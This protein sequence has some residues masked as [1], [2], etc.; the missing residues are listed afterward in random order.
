MNESSRGPEG[1]PSDRR[2]SDPRT[3]VTPDAFEISGDLLGLPLAGPWSRLW[4]L[5][6]DGILI[7]LLS[8]AGPLLLGVAAAV[9]F[10]RMALSKEQNAY[11]ARAFRGIMGCLGLGIL[12]VTGCGL[13]VFLAPD[14]EDAGDLL[15]GVLQSGDTP[16][17]D[18][19]EVSVDLGDVFS[20]ISEVQRFRRAE[21]EDE[22]RTSAAAVARRLAG[23]GAPTADIREAL[24]ELA[25]PDA[26]WRDQLSSIV[27][28]AVRSA[29]P[30]EAPGR[31]NSGSDVVSVP[32]A[33]SLVPADDLPDSLA[34]SLSVLHARLQEEIE[35]RETA[36]ARLERARRELE[37]ARDGGVVA[38]IEE[39]V[40][41]L[42][43]A[44]G[45]GAI[46]MTVFLTWWNGQTPGKRLM[47]IRV[48][49]LDGTPLG[50]WEAFERSGGYAAGFATGLLG[51]LQVFWDPNRQ[52]IHDKIAETVV[53]SERKES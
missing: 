33:D 41:E 8:L 36:E 40:D 42:G 14:V 35:D 49:Q 53:V 9:F 13:F 12:F 1:S 37:E 45:W 32:S 20:G 28:E 38:W 24:R 7:G 17:G 2:R 44:F 34:D 4:A 10:L 48:R 6:L 26:P 25:P 11:L 16:T 46:Y 29:A 3:E 19:Q 51:F 27:G 31:G 18:G 43:L 30:D 5:V 39:I 15:P 47:R 50:W 22:A 52:A 21:T 23:A